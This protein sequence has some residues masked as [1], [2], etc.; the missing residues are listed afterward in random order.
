MFLVIDND[1]KIFLIYRVTID[2]LQEL[3][4]SQ[5]PCGG[6]SEINRDFFN[7]SLDGASQEIGAKF[8]IVNNSDLA[9]ERVSK[10]DFALYEN[11]FYLKHATVK[12]QSKENTNSSDIKENDGGDYR[13]LHIMENCVINMPISIGLQKNSPIIKR[14]N[15][16]IRRVIEAGLVK[17]WLDDVMQKTLNSEK[18]TSNE[19]TK[20]LMS[21]RKMF[22]A[23]F[24]LFIGYF[25]SV[26]IL[27]AEQFYFIFYIKKHPRFDKFSKQIIN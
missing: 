8:E 27:I 22:G 21:L 9:I 1:N 6:F 18:S 19:S 26:T 17:K 20:T 3:V 14:V 2:T 10:G 15:K 7:T 13:G 23:F 11:A 16:Y 25:F 5:L 12:Q 4:D 24:A